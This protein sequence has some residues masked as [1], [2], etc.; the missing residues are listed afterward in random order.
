[1]NFEL[2]PKE[3][4]KKPKHAT[5]IYKNKAN[6]SKVYFTERNEKGQN[7][8]VSNEFDLGYV[9]KK[10]ELYHAFTY[11]IFEKFELN[12]PPQGTAANEMI[13]M[14]F[15]ERPD[16]VDL[17]IKTI[18]DSTFIDRFTY[19]EQKYLYA[20]LRLIY[21]SKQLKL[22]LLSQENQQLKA[23]LDSIENTSEETFNSDVYIYNE[24]ISEIKTN[25]K[26][27][28]LIHSL[29]LALQNLKKENS[30]LTPSEIKRVESSIF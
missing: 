20:L 16:K 2:K 6:V 1:M 8:R 10:H 29:R 7:R 22:N 25:E 17:F 23:E 4:S 24:E 26:T 12:L 5:V 15:D 14:G 13:I 28:F 21:T 11:Q 3:Q 9:T 30:G 18:L 27:I 19:P